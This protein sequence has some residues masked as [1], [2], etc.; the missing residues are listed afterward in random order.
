[1]SL[2]NKI[3]SKPFSHIVFDCDGTL[4]SIEGIDRL[5]EF[6]HCDKVVKELTAYAMGSCGLTPEIYRKRLNLIKPTKNQVKQL[7]TDYFTHQVKGVKTLFDILIKLQKKIYI[8][9]A[10]VYEAVCQFGTKLMIATD[11]IYAVS[12]YFNEKGEYVD[13]DHHSPL[14][15]NNGKCQL[16]KHLFSEHDSIAFIG[17]GLNDFAAKEVVERFIG[18]GGVFYRKNLAN[19]CDYYLTS[20]SLEEV[21]PLLLT[22]EELISINALP[23]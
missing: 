2:L 5:A 4:T 13:F 9:S 14:I 10:G 12:I 20:Y 18:F 8:F 19:Q 1:M 3:P 7:A 21:L 23:I 11:C 22:K 6:N 15:Y 16:I 17:D